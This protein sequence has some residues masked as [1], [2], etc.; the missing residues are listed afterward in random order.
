MG[1]SVDYSHHAVSPHCLSLLLLVS[2]EQWLSLILWR[3]KPP[4]K[5]LIHEVDVNMC[6]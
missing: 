3:N 1:N 4:I 2:A 6:W 5:L